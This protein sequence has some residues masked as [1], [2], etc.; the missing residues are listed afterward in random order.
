MLHWCTCLDAHTLYSL[1]CMMGTFIETKGLLILSIGGSDW[2]SGFFPHLCGPRF[3]SHLRPE[4][5]MWIG[6]FSLYLT[7]LVFSP[8]WG[9]PHTSKT[10]HLFSFP[11]HPVIDQIVLPDLQKSHKSNVVPSILQ[12]ITECWSV[13][14]VRIWALYKKPLL[15]L[16][17][18]IIK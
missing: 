18:I 3:E 9:F 14:S 5:C 6:F 7:A 1:P 13:L 11:I 12:E 17:L 16:L 15:L 2:L 8:I 10:E 4:P